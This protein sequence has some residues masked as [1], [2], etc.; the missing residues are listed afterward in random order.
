M[1][2]ISQSDID[3]KIVFGNQDN[4]QWMQFFGLNLN[5]REQC[6]NSIFESSIIAITLCDC[7]S[8]ILRID[9]R[10]R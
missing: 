1:K 7:I 8:Y 10:D 5:R 4:G 3:K 2:K 9:T 6:G